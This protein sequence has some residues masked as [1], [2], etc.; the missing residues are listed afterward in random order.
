MIHNIFFFLFVFLSAL[1]IRHESEFIMY[2]DFWLI[3]KVKEHA[4]GSRS[5]IATSPV[6][7][8][9]ASPLAHTFSHLEISDGFIAF[10][11]TVYVELK[12]AYLVSLDTQN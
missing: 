3:R 9:F 10:L 2:D 1:G 5:N 6:C 11:I 12:V 7:F 8:F 4:V